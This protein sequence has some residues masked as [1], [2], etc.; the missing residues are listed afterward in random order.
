MDFMNSAQFSELPDREAQSRYI[1]DLF[2][3][4]AQQCYPYDTPAAETQFQR[5]ATN[6][7]GCILLFTND[8]TYLLVSS[9][10][11]TLDTLTQY[12][13][14][15]FPENQM[16]ELD[17]SIHAIPVTTDQLLRYTSDEVIRA[18]PGFQTALAQ[19]EWRTNPD[20]LRFNEEGEPLFVLRGVGGDIENDVLFTS[21]Y[22]GC[23]AQTIITQQL[24]NYQQ[25]SDKHLE[26]LKIDFPSSEGRGALFSYHSIPFHSYNSV[27]Y[28]DRLCQHAGIITSALNADLVVWPVKYP[29]PENKGFE[30]ITIQDTSYACFPEIAKRQ[31]NSDYLKAIIVPLSFYIL[32]SLQYQRSLPRND[33]IKKADLSFTT[34]EAL[35]EAINELQTYHSELTHSSPS[36]GI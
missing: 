36:I 25:C 5:M 31:K 21:S 27:S 15:A 11:D 29:L 6:Q 16:F 23:D 18:I 9:N 2:E 4:A 19:I 13:E 24:I 28:N 10:K 35:D 17:D 8:F 1:R 30:I 34:D 20:A 12:N 7:N 22:F 33:R 32:A 3:H 14:N 26:K